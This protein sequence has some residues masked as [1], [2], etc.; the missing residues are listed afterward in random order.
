MT[1]LTGFS[2]STGLA[3]SCGLR[4]EAYF[5]KSIIMTAE[6]VRI[7]DE[8]LSMMKLTGTGGN[9]HSCTSCQNPSKAFDLA[10]SIAVERDSDLVVQFLIRCVDHTLLLTSAHLVVI[11]HALD[12]ILHTRKLLVQ[13]LR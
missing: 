4:V 3:G 2:T 9:C 5:K 13:A 8:R 12:F 10:L 11:E 1:S 7:E 6:I